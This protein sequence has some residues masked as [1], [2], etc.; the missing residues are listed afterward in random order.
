MRHSLRGALFFKVAAFDR[1]GSELR[2]VNV[3]ATSRERALQAVR[4]LVRGAAEFRVRPLRDAAI[5]VEG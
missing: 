4:R 2:T 3:R 5:F 1:D